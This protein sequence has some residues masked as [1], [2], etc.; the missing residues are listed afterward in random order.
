M[1]VICP[2]ASACPSAICKHKFPHEKESKCEE[3]ISDKFKRT[4]I[5]WCPSCISTDGEG[6][7]R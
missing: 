6:G 1:K 7:G 3:V 5:I 2:D 4:E